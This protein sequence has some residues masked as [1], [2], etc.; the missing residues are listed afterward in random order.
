MKNLMMFS[1]NTKFQAPAARS[2]TS[3]TSS[4]EDLAQDFG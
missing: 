2:A 4:M 3:K 1:S